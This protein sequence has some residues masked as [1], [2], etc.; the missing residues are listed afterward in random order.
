MEVKWAHSEEGIL[1]HMEQASRD[2][3]MR[4]RGKENTE[5]ELEQNE[6]GVS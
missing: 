3:H 5:N 6:G 1:C 2:N 4:Q